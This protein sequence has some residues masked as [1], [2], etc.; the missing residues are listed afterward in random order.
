MT[1]LTFL[2]TAASIPSQ[3][4]DNTSFLFSH[5]NQMILIDCPGAIVHKLLKSGTDAGGIKHVIITHSHV[6]HIYG[7]ID[8]LH[9]QM[10][11]HNTITIYS[12]PPCIRLIKKL[13]KLFKLTRSQFGGVH[14]VDVFSKE[15]FYIGGGVKIKAFHNIHIT[16]SFAIR[17]HWD[18]QTLGYT[19][20]TAL[21]TSLLTHLGDC[22][23]LIHECLA[24]SHFF[25][26]NPSL[27]TLHTDAKTLAA[28]LKDSPTKIVIPVHF[29]L[30]QAREETRIK[31]ELAPIA[32]KILFV[33]DFQRVNLKKS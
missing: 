21:S 25:K 22:D 18:T 29:L 4:R 30:T 19:S 1:T 7:V 10:R 28:H 6:D 27:Y 16:G 17:I 23:Y 5:N 8:L 2:G 31:K 12:T 3:H 11:F 13:V 9:C 24:S 26:K 15:Y 20:D 32:K 33:K 14:F